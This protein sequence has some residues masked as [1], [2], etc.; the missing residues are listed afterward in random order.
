MCLSAQ[1]FQQSRTPD[2]LSEIAQS[3]R[4]STVQGE[5]APSVNGDVCAALKWKEGGE[6]QGGSAEESRRPLLLET[7]QELTMESVTA[8]RCVDLL[9]VLSLL[10]LFICANRIISSS[11]DLHQSSSTAGKETHY[12]SG[13]REGQ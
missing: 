8:A 13:V 7:L 9:L 6:D 4:P 12:K 3:E 11:P 2:W 1:T 5:A 10:P